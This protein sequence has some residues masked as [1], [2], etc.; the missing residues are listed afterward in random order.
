M[1]FFSWLLYRQKLIVIS[2]HVTVLNVGKEPKPAHYIQVSIPIHHLLFTNKHVIMADTFSKVQKVPFNLTFLDID[3]LPTTDPVSSLTGTVGD[4]TVLRV[5]FDLDPN[6]QA[7]LITGWLIGVNN[8]VVDVIF[9]G[10]G[11]NGQVTGKATI[12]ITDG[13]PAVKPAASIGVVLGDAV[14]Q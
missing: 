1:G 8:G 4:G 13:I 3:G 14:A 5:L 11:A 10:V 6:T 7:P 12:T 2:N 9:T